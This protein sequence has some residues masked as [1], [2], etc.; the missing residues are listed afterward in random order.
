MLLSRFVLG[1]FSAGLMVP[2][3]G[4]ASG[5]DYPNNP[6]R[7]V[8]ATVGGGTDLEARLIAQGISAPLG[9]QV[10]VDNRPGIIGFELVANA[11]PDGYTLLLAS[12]PFFVGPLLRKM[13]YD[14]ARDFLPITLVS[15]APNV[16]V[17][18]PSLPVKSVKELIAFAKA[19]PGEL[20]Y[21]SGSLGSSTHLPLELFKAMVGVN[22]VRIAYKGGGQ[23]MID[24]I[25]G[26]V[27]L[28]FATAPSA[29]PYVKAGKLRALAITSAQSSA[30]LPGLLTVA[31]SGLP[32]Y[33]YLGLD[34]AFAPA[35]TPA[36]II[37]RLNQEI[38]RFLRTP[39]TRKKFLLAARIEPVASSPEELAAA[40]KADVTRLGKVIKDAG[41]RAQ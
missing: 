6:V 31:A 17:V 26:R 32:G 33:E 34:G 27:H 36:A 7:I 20:N 39:D 14:P 5:Q 13:R 8:A 35:K 18:H 2:G 40:M 11:P 3:V 19:R 21:G 15:R 41:I 38:V 24:L 22:I 23:A 29:M 16:V 25:A 1:M 10:L 28:M 12:S 37:N 4:V 9:Q 30:L